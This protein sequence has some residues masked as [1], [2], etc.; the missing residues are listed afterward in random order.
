VATNRVPEAAVAEGK[1]REDLWYRLKVFP[2]EL[3]PLRD[4]DGDVALLAEHFLAALNTEH[5]TAKRWSAAALEHLA[6]QSWPGNVRELKNVV[7]RAHILAERVLTVDFLNPTDSRAASAATRREAV[8]AD[9][10]NVAVQVG[11]TVAEAE[12][13]LIEATLAHCGGNK[14]RTAEML[15]V[16]L[17]TL[18][19]RLA[20]YRGESEHT[21]N[22]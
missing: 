7:H 18:Y 15:G 3:P 16:S 13:Q 6:G 14:Q 17:K 12:R 19:N 10:Q 22:D 4:R 21:T 5:G 20:A 9:P 8:G 2:I 11:H 1:L